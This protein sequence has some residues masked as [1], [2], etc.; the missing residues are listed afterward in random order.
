M[1]WIAQWLWIDFTLCLVGVTLHVLLI[2]NVYK[3]LKD[4]LLDT[5]WCKVCF[6]P[7]NLP[8]LTHSPTLHLLLVNEPEQHLMDQYN[9]CTAD[10]FCLVSSCTIQNIPVYIRSNISYLIQ[11]Q[12]FQSLV[13]V[14]RELTCWDDGIITRNR[15]LQQ[16]L[17]KVLK[18]GN[19]T[20]V[21]TSCFHLKII[22]LCR[23]IAR[24]DWN[25]NW[26]PIPCFNYCLQFPEFIK[27]SSSENATS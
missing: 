3:V 23:F 15:N 21:C 24:V 2:L 17:E 9:T 25:Q 20:L 12:S 8:H 4:N 11:R 7:R 13:L 6:C 16:H 5:C 18:T 26:N 22:H 19:F 10:I 14:F 27:I 1:Y